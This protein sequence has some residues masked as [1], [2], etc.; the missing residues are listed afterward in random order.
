MNGQRTITKVS[1]GFIIQTG[2]RI[3]FCR[4]TGSKDLIDLPKGLKENNETPLA[5]ALR[6]LREETGIVLGTDGIKLADLGME[7]YSKAKN[8]HLFYV[9]LPSVDLSQLHC[10][11]TFISKRW[12]TLTKPVER[13]EVDDYYLLTP[14]EAWHRL[15]KGMQNYFAMKRE[16]INIEAHHW[17]SF[18]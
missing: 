11:S 2:F 10:S 4:P 6:E 18:A 1:C 5:A 15:S 3:L 14:I 13:P 12:S 17:P 16:L 8:L 7:A 9:V